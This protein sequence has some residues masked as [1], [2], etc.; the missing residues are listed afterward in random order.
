MM[1]IV[2]EMKNEL[3]RAA[4]ARNLERYFRISNLR[5]ADCLAW[6][7]D[8]REFDINTDEGWEDAMTK[9]VVRI[10]LNARAV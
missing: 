8:P 9:G 6:H 7:G 4:V 3:S 5:C 1:V 2:K 10:Y